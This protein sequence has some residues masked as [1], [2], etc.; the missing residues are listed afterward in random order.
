MPGSG[1]E[2]SADVLEVSRKFMCSLYGK[3]DF[4]GSLDELRCHLFQ[5]K[6]SDIRF[7]PPTTDAF[8]LHLKRALYQVLIW[9]RATSETLML[10][11]P[12][13]FG[14]TIRNGSLMACLMTKSPKPHLQLS[15]CNCRKDRCRSHCPCR[16]AKPRVLCTLACSCCGDPSLCEN[17]DERDPEYLFIFLLC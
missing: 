17:I 16:K 14:R 7:L 4:T 9:K 8:Y 10:P 6:R 13:D 5:T 3:K 1:T 11:P 2:I 12:T 15:K